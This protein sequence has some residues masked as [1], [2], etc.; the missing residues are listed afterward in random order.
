ML[1]LTAVGSASCQVA[2]T[3][4]G[5][6]YIQS[7]EKTQLRVP[8][9]VTGN[10]LSTVYAPLIRDGRMQKFLWEPNRD[11]KLGILQAMFAKDNMTSG[12]VE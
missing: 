9:I 4:S 5:S 7:T 3:K 11:D 12:Q 10:D 6:S 1:R 8:I 2:S